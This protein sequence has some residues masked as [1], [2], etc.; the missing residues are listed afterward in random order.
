MP[1]RPP[2][3]PTKP[4]RIV[5]PAL[6]VVAVV[7]GLAALTSFVFFAN[8]PASLNWSGLGPLQLVNVDVLPIDP[9]N[10]RVA[11]VMSVLCRDGSLARHE[12]RAVL[13]WNGD[14]DCVYRQSA[15]PIDA[16]WPLQELLDIDASLPILGHFQWGWS[17]SHGRSPGPHCDLAIAKFEE[18]IGTA[19]FVSPPLCARLPA[20]MSTQPVSGARQPSASPWAVYEPMLLAHGAFG[21]IALYTLPVLVCLLLKNS[22]RNVNWHA[23][24]RR[25]ACVRCAYSLANLSAATCPECG[26]PR[27]PSSPTPTT[28][29]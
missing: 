8:R 15:N 25:G 10:Q 4:P 19:N 16:R 27:V 26:T 22:V 23:R 13:N 7:G 6:I 11:V 21:A 28:P 3:D 2:R 1:R 29:H 18:W 24:V 14:A 9:D 5:T 17:V 12:V 20:H